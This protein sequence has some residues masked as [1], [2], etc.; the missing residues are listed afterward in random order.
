M[1]LISLQLQDFK[2]Y[3]DALIEFASGTNAIVGHNGAGK[4][5]ILEALGFA[6]FGYKPE[7]INQ[8]DLVR[9]GANSATITVTF[10]SSRD[11]RAYQVI[12]RVGSSNRYE[13]FDPELGVRV[14]NGTDD[15]QDFLREHMG[16]DPEVKLADFFANAVGVPQG[17]FTSAFLLTPANRR[18]VFDPLLRVEEFKNAV[19]KLR[20]P[21]RLLAERKQA[22]D[23]TISG[24]S[25]RLERLPA[26]RQEA[27][28]LTQ[29]IARNR[30]ALA[31]VQAD[32]AQVS[33]ERASQE[34]Q[35]Q[36]IADL[37]GRV[38]QARSQLQNWQQQ[39][40][41]ARKRLA[42]ATQAA[43]IVAENEA[44]HRAYIQAQARQ[45]ELNEQ[46]RQRQALRDER[47]GLLRK[48][49][50]LEARLEGWRQSLAEAQA[51][52]G[53][54]A[55]LAPAA[56][57]Q[58]QLEADL[59]TARSQA[60][61]LADLRGQV[62]RQAAQ[63]AQQEKALATMRSQV[64]E[65]QKVEDDLAQAR[66]QEGELNQELRRQTEALGGFKPEADRIKE[67]NEGLA[68]GDGSLCPVCE[69]P[70]DD[71]HR[72]GLIQRNEEALDRLRQEWKQVK[73]RIGQLEAQ[74]AEAKKRIAG[75][76]A[77]LRKLPRSAEADRAAQA[78]ADLQAQLGELTSRV[79]TLGDP[80]AQV[81]QLAQALADLG[82]PRSRRAAAS[83][84][85]AKGEKLAQEVAGGEAELAHLSEQVAALDQALTAFASLDGELAQV[86]QALGDH[87]TADD[88]YRRHQQLAQQQAERQQELA[89]AAA[90]LAQAEAGLAER[91]AAHAAQASAFDQ[92]AFVEL[93]AHE[94]DLRSRLG[95]LEGQLSQQEQRSQVLAA[96]EGQLTAQQAELESAQAGQAL[97]TAQAETLEQ[98]RKILR[99]AGPFVTQA[100]VQQISH[101]ASQLFGEIMQDFTRRL[102]WAED[103]AILLEVDGRERQ[104][105]QLSGG[106]QMSAALAVRLALLQEMSELNVAFFDEPTTNLDEERRSALARQIVNIQGF[107][108]LFV[109]SHDDAFEQATENL[110][111][112]R[113]VNGVSVVGEGGIG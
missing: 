82:D 48:L 63:V 75:G 36:I 71:A 51:A 18:S 31:Q 100:L 17:S 54:A 87:Q 90:S 23:V 106:E 102:R 28:D 14:C 29:A 65:A 40:A 19:E 103:Y 39:E 89:S 10:A 109:I 45:G 22:L 78:L 3:E 26:L 85:A 57:R 79:D 72:A 107:N 69:Q 25:A 15:V 59:Q 108:Q 80:A 47:G 42:E 6:L 5:S 104:F 38:E 66:G 12:R 92:A 27:A 99:E 33:Q 97:L 53:E 49:S 113:K 77:R 91:E 88:R 2:S 46:S 81:E 11:E 105:S 67:Q 60:S 52:Q 55:E 101:Q 41:T 112:I 73:D 93:M 9:E 83:R 95:S 84:T 111:R 37:L 8:G 43:Q 44:G 70:L 50:A 98:L 74:Q 24:L 58:E 96:E 86:S 21:A 62:D 16:I 20:E 1:N 7:G 30:T 13:I 56:A 32:L 35:R 94:Q 4:S 110:I 68:K 34:E 64:A 76:E 61:Q